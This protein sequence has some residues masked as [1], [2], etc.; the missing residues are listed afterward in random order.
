VNQL[1]AGI[2]VGTTSVK[3]LVLDEE[4]RVVH[5]RSRELDLSTPRP[6]WYEQDP[7]Q[8]WKAAKELLTELASAGLEPE[9][10]GLT[11]QMHS[12]VLLDGEGNVLRPAILWNDQRT[13]EECVEMTKALEGERKV[14]ERLGNPILPGFTAPKLLW[15]KKNEPEI[16]EKARTFLLPKDYIAYKLT[17]S[18]HTEPSDASGTSLFSVEKNRWDDQVFSLFFEGRIEPPKVVESSA[19]VGELLPDVACEIGFK[20]RAKVVAGGADNACA[21]LGMGVMEAS[22][23]VVSVGTS[24]T[25]MVTKEKYSPDT[26]GRIHLFRHVIPGLY[27]HMGVILSATFS[28]DWIVENLYG[29]VSTEKLHEIL[30]GANEIPPLP[31][32]VF[33]LPYL[34]G[35]RTPHRDPNARGV[36]FGLSG[37][38]R[39]N[40]ILR[41]VMEGVAFALRDCKDAMDESSKTPRTARITGG[42]SKSELWVKILSSVMDV[43]LERM[44][45]N[46]GASMGAAMLAGMACGKDVSQWNTPKDRFTPEPMWKSTYERGLKYYKELYLRLKEIM[47]AT[48][49]FE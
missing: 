17:G 1:Y 36:L 15:V 43:E 12:L 39:R 46:E 30:A 20:K 38:V 33:F 8:W 45:K 40:A 23:M 48:R 7:H 16:F 10:I 13:G 42:G 26:T 4:G 14:I 44:E 49:E 3:L 31:E 35:E 21:A 27:Y 41:S 9:A 5:R 47:Q 24:G 25:V 18:L 29:E 19:V 37:K 6:G 22:Q 34:S 32:G 28:L 11:G 2:D